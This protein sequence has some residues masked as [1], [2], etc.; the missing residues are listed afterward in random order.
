[1]CWDFRDI[2]TTVSHHQLFP[3]GHLGKM[4]TLLTMSR[5]NKSLKA[6]KL[7]SEIQAFNFKTV[8]GTKVCWKQCLLQI[9]V[10]HLA[11]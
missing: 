7:K 1:M 9:P 3:Q 8:K 4:E 5:R 10:L 6:I 11:A 2:G